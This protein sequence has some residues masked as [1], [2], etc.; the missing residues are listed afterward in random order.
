MAEACRGVQRPEDWM[1]KMRQG[2]YRGVCESARWLDGFFGAE[3][4]EV[5]EGVTYG[6]IGLGLAWDEED[7]FRE[8]ARLRARFD[9]PRLEQ[10]WNAFVGRYDE[11]EF[12]T[13]RG[14]DLGSGVPELFRE[15]P[16]R[17]W[18]A[19]LGYSPVRSGRS[20]FDVDAGV[21]LGFPMDPFVRA[22]YRYYLF[23]GQVH[24]V[25]YR[26]TVFW[27]RE[28]GYGTTGRVDLERVL[29]QRSHL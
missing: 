2:V 1:E 24:L 9:L 20:R 27:R 25:R 6:R 29:G 19:G 23:L 11:E 16:A 12:V 21:K 15:N 3:S 28:R 26:H 5:E 22:K 10:R 17:D 7:G 14:D 13:G 4:V 8:R 18:L